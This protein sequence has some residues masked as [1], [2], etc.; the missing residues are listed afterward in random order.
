MSGDSLTK[1]GAISIDSS[2]DKILMSGDSLTKP[3]AIII[4]PVISFLC[5]VI[6]LRSPVLAV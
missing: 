6:V 4:A 3:G 1:P 5:P 2:G